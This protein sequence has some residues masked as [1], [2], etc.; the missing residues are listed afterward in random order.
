MN[1]PDQ[2]GKIEPGDRLYLEYTAIEASLTF[3]IRHRFDPF[4]S[5][6]PSMLTS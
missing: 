4:L 5:G 2:R 1:N 6:A 3:L